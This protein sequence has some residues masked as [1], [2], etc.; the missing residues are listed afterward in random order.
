M[1][2][3]DPV[4]LRLLDGFQRDLPVAPRPYR[5]IG[6]AL[7]LGEAEVIARLARLVDCGAV[8]RVG[9]T[10]RPNTA[11]ASTLAAMAL[12]DH[13]IEE[14]AAAV[15][16]EEGVNHSYLRENRFNLWFVATGPDRAAVQRLLDRLRART[17]LAVLDLPLVRPFNVDLGF[18]L[19]GLSP[20]PPAREAR[21]GRARGRRPADPAGAVGRARPDP[22]PV[23]GAGGG[24]RPHRGRDPRAA[25]APCWRRG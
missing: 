25:S 5:E 11:G 18:A 14:V 16:A 12:P 7:G 19:D 10:C 21:P 23:R 15:G 20:P 9:G 22:A 13:R 17:R 4:D 2:L 6:R 24:P 8:T 1:L 3:G